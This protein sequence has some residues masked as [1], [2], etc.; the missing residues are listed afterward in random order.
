MTEVL[1]PRLGL[2]QESAI[3]VEWLKSVGDRVRRGEAL[4]VV[5]TDKTETEVESEYDGVLTRILVE[6]GEEVPVLTPIAL[7]R[8]PDDR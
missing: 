6:A 4:V 7:L 8:R 3:V 1:M 5:G 2:T